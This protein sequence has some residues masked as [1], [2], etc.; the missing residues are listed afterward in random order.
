M[1]DYLRRNSAQKIIIALGLA[2]VCVND[3]GFPSDG[4]NA[5]SKTPLK[6]L[7][8]QTKEVNES[9]NSSETQP[10]VRQRVQAAGKFFRVEGEKWYLRGFSYGLFA[11]N[12]RGEHFP[13]RERML[14]DFAHMRLLG[15]NARNDRKL[16]MRAVGAS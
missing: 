8:G 7:F 2:G 5:S 15:A 1:F 11:P 12:S 6:P 4:S 16:W 9:V 3:R 13:E 14:A 10:N